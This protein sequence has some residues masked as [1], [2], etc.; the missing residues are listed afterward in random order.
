MSVKKIGVYT[1]P[2]ALTKVGAGVEYIDGDLIEPDERVILNS[3][4]VEDETT[5]LTHIRIGK[6]SG[7]EFILWEESK[8]A[9]AGQLVHSQEEHV[10][11]EGE[12]FRAELSGGAANDKCRVYLDGWRQYLE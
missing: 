12:H 9:L 2:L 6:I 11:A 3:I 4:A 5:A 1:K 8:G 10:L 7:K